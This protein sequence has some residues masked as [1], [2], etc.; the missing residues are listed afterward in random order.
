LQVFCTF[1]ISFIFCISSF[2]CLNHFCTSVLWV[3]F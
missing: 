3:I 2:L 1:Y